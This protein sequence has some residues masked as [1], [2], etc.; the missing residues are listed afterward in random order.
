MEQVAAE[1]ARELAV[2]GAEV[3]PA[4]SGGEPVGIAITLDRHPDPADPDPWTGLLM[5]DA[6]VQRADHRRQL[7]GLLEDGFRGAGR[8]GLKLAVLDGNPKELALWTELGYRVIDRP[9]DRQLG[10]SCASCVKGR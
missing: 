6:R 7:A 4:R 1:P 10:R 9:K 5:V 3:L 8:T 2:P